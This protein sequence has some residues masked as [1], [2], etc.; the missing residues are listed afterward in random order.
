MIRKATYLRGL[1]A[2]LTTRGPYR[3]GQEVNTTSSRA[4]QPAKG[5]AHSRADKITADGVSAVVQKAYLKTE[6][7]KAVTA[8]LVTEAINKILANHYQ[9]LPSRQ[10][11]FGVK[12]KDGKR[13]W[14]WKSFQHSDQPA[15]HFEHIKGASTDHYENMAGWKNA[16]APEG[17]PRGSGKTRSEGR[18]AR[19]RRQRRF[20]G[21]PQPAGIGAAD[22]S[23]VKLNYVDNVKAPA[24]AKRFSLSH[25]NAR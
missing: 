10:Q 23:M 12:G 18:A 11:L 3:S 17:R 6:A 15:G 4:K 1:T 16:T 8:S 9:I 14:N 21:T 22:W 2:G 7:E 24:L 5:W 20:D 25:E 13:A 19:L